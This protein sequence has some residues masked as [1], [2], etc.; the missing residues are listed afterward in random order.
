MPEVGSLWQ[1]G[2]TLDFTP[3]N[4]YQGELADVQDRDDAA[5]LIDGRCTGTLIE[6]SAGPVV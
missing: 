1:R 4:S 2:P 3:I 5:V 6:A